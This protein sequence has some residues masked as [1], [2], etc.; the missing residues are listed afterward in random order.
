MPICVFFF[1][2]AFLIA[3]SK[4]EA[5]LDKVRVRARVRVRVR[6]GVSLLVVTMKPEAL[7][8]KVASLNPPPTPTP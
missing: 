2:G 3:T 7:L 6:V 8:D 4:P 1:L 5:L